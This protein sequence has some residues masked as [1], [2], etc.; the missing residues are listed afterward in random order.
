MKQDVEIVEV[1]SDLQDLIP[2]FIN[3]R[4]KDLSDLRELVEAQDFTGIAQMAH[5]I[6]GSSAGY[7]F[8]RLSQLASELEAASKK[9]YSDDI[10]KIYAKMSTYFQNV[11]V[12]YV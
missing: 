4:K 12:R 2:N 8:T 1:E 6:K 11:E 10:P 7:G 5:R 9:H 3:N